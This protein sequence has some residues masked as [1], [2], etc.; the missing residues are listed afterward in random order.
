VRVSFDPVG[1]YP[2][3]TQRPDLVRTPGGRSL[4]ELT[5]DALRA[6][7]LTPEEMRVTPEALERQAAVARAAG[8][9]QLAASF[10]RAAE[11]TAL[12]AEL[13]L[14]IYTALRP[15]RSTAQE[16]EQWADRLELEFAAPLTAAFVREAKALYAD[17]DLL[18]AG[19]QAA[20]TAV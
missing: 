2:L 4:D 15:R 18:L 6:G 17:H 3:G 14:E 16:L 12:P 13:I 1:D 11:L 8:R 9:P 19:E 7:E 10:E 5:L 20:S